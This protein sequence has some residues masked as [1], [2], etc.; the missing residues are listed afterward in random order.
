LGSSNTSVAG[1]H[2]ILVIDQYWIG[3]TETA[4]AVGDLPNLLFRMGAGVRRPRVEYG[5]RQVFDLCA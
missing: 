3:E 4:N 2:R 1:E 5:R